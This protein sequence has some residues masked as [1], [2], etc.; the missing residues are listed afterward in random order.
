MP[1]PDPSA[2]LVLDFDG[3]VCIGD[4]PVLFYAEEVAARHPAAAD[5]VEQVREFLSGERQIDGAADGYHAVH[6]LSAAA[7][8]AQD[9]LRQAYLASRSRLDAGEGETRA[10]HGLTDALA[11][12][13]QA[14]VRI[15]LATN[16][17]RIGIEKWLAGRDLDHR[18]DEVIADAGKPAGMPALLDQVA[19]R[20]GLQV[21]A[22]LGSIGDVWANDVGPAMERGG[23]G[24]FI[25]RFGTGQEPSSYTGTTFEDLL[26]AMRD[27]AAQPR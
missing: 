18:I 25:D 14:D 7:G 16:S 22:A 13:R 20:A 6:R 5:V 9:L 11:D 19:T 26:P 24:F 15:V 12:L 2:A 23:T 1:T 4:D 10:P 8:A 21:P 17:P 3:T 27:W